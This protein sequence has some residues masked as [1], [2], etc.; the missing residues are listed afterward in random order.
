MSIKGR[1]GLPVPRLFVTQ[2][3]HLL[4]FLFYP[5]LTTLSLLKNQLVGP[6]RRDCCLQLLEFPA[7][8]LEEGGPWVL[9]LLGCRPTWFCTT[10]WYRLQPRPELSHFSLPVLLPSNLNDTGALAQ[11][12]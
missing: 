6:R 1:N 12:Q 5:L 7:A 9:G 8:G 11:Q 2:L 4:L 10:S 3:H